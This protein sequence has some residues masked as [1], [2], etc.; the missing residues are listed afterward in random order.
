MG[1]RMVKKIG[2]SIFLLQL[3]IAGKVCRAEPPFQFVTDVDDTI[4][5]TNVNSYRNAIYRGIY[6]SETFLG[7]SQ[8]YRWMSEYA[9]SVTYLSASPVLM[10]KKI[11]N[12]L[13]GHQFPTGRLIV[14]NWLESWLNGD[15]LID[16]KRSRLK[17]LAAFDPDA[18]FILIGDDTQSDPVIFAEFRELLMKRLNSSVG[19]VSAIY[20]HRVQGRE[21]PGGVIPFVSAFDIALHE[22]EAGRLSYE[23]A[24]ELGNS[25]VNSGHP[26]LILPN[27]KDCPKRFSYSD[28]PKDPYYLGPVV[29]SSSEL[30]ATSYLVAAYI[31]HYCNFRKESLKDMNLNFHSPLKRKSGS[32]ND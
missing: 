20:I 25:I 27:F 11:K 7:M 26:E 31:R 29:S 22:V 16:Y 19:G 2:I 32:F 8:L 18:P 4:K 9:R 30:L 13:E 24:I 21:L 14:S 5:V 28:D 23:R 12:L 1:G 3:L 17:L 10:S 15:T 6:R